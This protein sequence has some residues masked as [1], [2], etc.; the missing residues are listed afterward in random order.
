[1]KKDPKMDRFGTHFPLK[2]DAK[3]NAENGAKKTWKFMKFELQN[4][5]KSRSKCMEKPDFS[6]QLTF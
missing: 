5:P 1:M 4:I 2:N 3:I 6:V